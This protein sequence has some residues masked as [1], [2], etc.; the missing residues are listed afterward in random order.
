MALVFLSCGQRD[1]E[2]EIALQIQQMIQGKEFGM[3]CYNADSV[4]GFDDVM[5]ITQR[6]S[7][8]DYYLFIDF[9]RDGAERESDPPISVFSAPRVRSGASVGNHGDD[10]ISGGRTEILRNAILSFLCIRKDLPVTDWWIWCVRKFA[11][12]AG[13]MTT[14]GI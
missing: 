13:V 7:R 4:Q 8:A 10:R 1:G 3:E 6:L 14:P 12:R 11:A 5:S 2:R 9:R